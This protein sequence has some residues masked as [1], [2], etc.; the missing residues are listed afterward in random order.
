VTRV[1]LLIA[2]CC[3][4]AALAVPQTA[5]AVG[6][7]TTPKTIFTEGFETPVAVTYVAAPYVAGGGLTP[8]YWKRVTA[9]QIVNPAHGGLSY[10]WCDG[11]NATQVTRK[12]YAIGSQGYATFTLTQTVDYYK[13]VA[14]LW[15]SFPTAG[16]S[17]AIAFAPEWTTPAASGVSSALN[18]VSFPTLLNEWKPMTI[19]LA[20]QTTAK[21]SLSRAAGT[22]RLRWKDQT[23]PPNPPP[24]AT[25]YTPDGQGPSVD[26]VTISGWKFG[27]V[28]SLSA[29]T[30][31]ISSTLTWM[32]P[33]RSAMPTETSLEEC[34]LS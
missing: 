22:F 15:Y 28:R 11:T 32:R 8:G 29:T 21:T 31:S 16:Y 20:S 23:E 5:L 24:P 19:N 30:T 10:L 26:D 18:S 27:P 1:R 14:S 7:V 25:P 34:P 13:P 9:P 4:V 33:L 2:M 17:D 3:A 6:P 12:K